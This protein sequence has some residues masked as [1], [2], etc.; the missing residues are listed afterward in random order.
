MECQI[1]TRSVGNKKKKGPK[2]GSSNRLTSPMNEDVGF[3]NN[4]L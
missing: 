1:I 4:I 2:M 3:I